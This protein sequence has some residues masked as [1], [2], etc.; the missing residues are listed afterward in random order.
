MKNMHAMQMQSIEW[1]NDHHALIKPLIS[2]A[3]SFVT[4][5]AARMM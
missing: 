5:S 2:A 4:I 3:G 1:T